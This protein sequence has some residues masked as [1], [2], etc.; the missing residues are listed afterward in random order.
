MW[1]PAPT[2]PGGPGR[3]LLKDIGGGSQLR[4]SQDPEQAGVIDGSPDH[5]PA[6]VAL[7]RYRERDVV[8]DRCAA[9]HAAM[10]TPSRLANVLV[11]L[12]LGL[13]GFGPRHTS[14]LIG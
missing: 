6:A 3:Y 9:E 2:S 13:V 8:P 4:P 11:R 12:V 5:L 1:R 10:G 14:S 7:H